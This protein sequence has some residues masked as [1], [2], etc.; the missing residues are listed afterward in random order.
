MG[1]CATGLSASL[2]C[3]FIGLCLGLFLK[4]VLIPRLF[5]HGLLCYR[6]AALLE[7]NNVVLMCC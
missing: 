6:H 5:W 3:S 1:Y 4:L 7:G 2:F